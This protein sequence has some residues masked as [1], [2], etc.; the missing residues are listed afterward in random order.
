MTKPSNALRVAVL[1]AGVSSLGHVQ[2]HHSYA[3]FDHCHLTR[4]DGE[5]VGLEWVNRTW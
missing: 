4:L 1:A 2:A 5:I 3:M